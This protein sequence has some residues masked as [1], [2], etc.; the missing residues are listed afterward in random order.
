M[1]SD[2]DGTG[3][4]LDALDPSDEEALSR[5]LIAAIRPEPIADQRHEALI[6]AALLDPL[7]EPS[8]DER[9]RA[10]GLRAALETGSTDPDADL[11]RALAAAFRPAPADAGAL[12]TRRAVLTA[13]PRSKVIAV[14]FAATAAL[15]LAAG[16]ALVLAPAARDR[17]VEVE[18]AESRSLSPLFA[19]EPEKT[20]SERLD[21]IVAVRSR[22]LRD[23]RFAAWGVR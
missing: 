12:A 5:A 8:A 2:H 19:R 9:A 14:A 4:A 22:E 6:E 23:N 7:A 16:V 18:L 3:E 17:H 21:R 13:L 10:D 20:E 1:T 11:A 15:S